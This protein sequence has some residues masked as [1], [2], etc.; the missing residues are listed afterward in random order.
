MRSSLLAYAS[1]NYKVHS[2]LSGYLLGE[3]EVR[4]RIGRWA[5]RRRWNGDHVGRQT[6]EIM[7]RRVFLCGEQPRI[8]NE[9]DVIM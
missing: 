8:R 6:K 3:V 5:G 4:G 7:Y 9:G 2:L 1:F